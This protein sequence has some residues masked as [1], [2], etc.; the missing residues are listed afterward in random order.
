MIAIVDYGLGNLASV[1]NA[2]RAVGAD[3]SVTSDPD[4]IRS[5]SG[6]V[7]PGVGAASA[8]M[9]R[10]RERGLDRVVHEVASTERPLLGICLGMQLLFDRS[11]EG[12]ADCLGLI[13]GTVRLLRSDEKIPHIGWNQAAFE[14]D[15]PLRQGLP[16]DPYFYFVHSYVCEPLDASVVAARTEYG[17]R[18][19]SAVCQRQIWGTQFHPERSGRTGLRL[20][21]SFVDSLQPAARSGDIFP[22]NQPQVL[23]R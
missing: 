6:V 12:G 14:P 11:D 16:P 15:A 9:E 5:A 22:E 8:G 1:R 4:V 18:F 13:P 20:I 19:C 23:G 7:L 21:R 10:L 3:V 17:E 2:F